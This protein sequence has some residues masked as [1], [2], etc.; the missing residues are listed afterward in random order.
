M[1]A[2]LMYKTRKMMYTTKPY[3]VAYFSYHEWAEPPNQ[4]LLELL[5]KKMRSTHYFYAVS[6]TTSGKYDYIL[7]THL[8][9]LQQVFSKYSSKIVIEINAQLINAN[10]NQTIASKEFSIEKKTTARTPYSGV[11][12]ANKAASQ[13]LNE[14]TQFCIYHLSK[15]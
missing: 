2:P 6:T 7:Y 8:I 9:Q 15:H 14:I 10:T 3:E 12:A 5:A 13:L 1:D 11:I 4:M